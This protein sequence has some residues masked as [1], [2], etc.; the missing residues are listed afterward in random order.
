MLSLDNLK[1]YLRKDGNSFNEWHH[2]PTMPRGS[3]CILLAGGDVEA[4]VVNT[5]SNHILGIQLKLL[6]VAV[7]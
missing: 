3:F 6:E 1:L 2:S 5:K 4:G 7:D